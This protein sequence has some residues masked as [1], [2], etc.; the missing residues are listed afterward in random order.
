VV[1]SVPAATNL[2]ILAYATNSGVANSLV[3]GGTY[4][5]AV[6]NAATT[7]VSE[8]RTLAN[9]KR[10][11]YVDGKPFLALGGQLR[12]D[13]WRLYEGYSNPQ[14][15]DLGIFSWATNLNINVV[16]VPVYWSDCEPTQNSFN[17]TNLQWAIG[18]CA[19]YGLRMEILWFGSDISGQGDSNLEPGYILKNPNAY[20]LMVSRSG[21]VETN[22]IIGPGGYEWT[23]SKE[24]PG[25]IAA[26]ANVIY[27]MMGYLKANDTNHVVIGLLVEG[28]V[29]IMADADPPTD[30]DYSPGANA[31]Y[32]AGGY[33]NGIQFSENR[34]PVY[35]NKLAAAVKGSPYQMFAYVNWVGDYWE[36]DENVILTRQVAT[37]LDFIGWDPYGPNQ[38]QHYLRL[39]GDLSSASNLPYAEEEP[40]GQD[41]TCRQK[42]I[43][44]FAANGG[45]CCFYRVDSYPNKNDVDNYLIYLHGTNGVDGRPWTDE[46][47][48][49]FGM[50]EKVMGKL[51]V[52]A[53][54]TNANTRIQYFN[55]FGNTMISYRG[56][57]LLNGA[58]ILY[59]TSTAGVGI[60]FVD[61]NATV[62]MSAKSGS[63]TLPALGGVFENGFYNANGNWV[64]TSLHAATT[65]ADGTTTVN[66]SPSKPYEVVRWIAPSPSQ[67]KN[68]L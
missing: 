32:T 5:T 64:A 31:L 28:E 8:V 61:G 20:P 37:N 9:G 24:Y 57:N 47:R 51:A 54:T 25:A 42:I 53:Y 17:W 67:L 34:L 14:M 50:L 38:L 49:T 15:T 26:E 19:K 62:L 22:A 23:L 13:T 60:A 44:T 27:N 2:A 65:N 56:T 33:T 41:G 12:P 43:D 4:Y 16:Q 68:K 36:Y 45:G 3:S 10:V 55:S 46:I 30:R 21:A 1:V 63:F 40:G 52:L 35:L 39:K 18:E 66:L 6:T 48:Q 29:S 7:V 59:D 11:L 58:A